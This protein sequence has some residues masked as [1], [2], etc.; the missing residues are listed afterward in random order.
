MFLNDDKPS[1]PNKVH[2]YF[3][4]VYDGNIFQ[5]TVQILSSLTSILVPIEGSQSKISLKTN[6][7]SAPMKSTSWVLCEYNLE[8]CTTGGFRI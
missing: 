1:T 5:T 6:I 7:H 8:A 2:I 4:Y 3:I